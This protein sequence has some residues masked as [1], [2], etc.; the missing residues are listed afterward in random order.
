M[1]EIDLTAYANAFETTLSDEL[2]LVFFGQYNT[3]S[4]KNIQ[5]IERFTCLLRYLKNEKK[6]GI[7][8]LAFMQSIAT[9]LLDEIL[10]LNINFNEI[11]IYI[12]P[13]ICLVESPNLCKKY[14]KFL[15]TRFYSSEFIN[16]TYFY[17]CS[18]QMGNYIIHEPSILRSFGIFSIQSHSE[19]LYEFFSSINSE[20]LFNK[21]IRLNI[22]RQTSDIYKRH[23]LRIC[24]KTAC[25]YSAYEIIEYLLHTYET[26]F[27]E[28]EMKIVIAENIFNVN[29]YEY[30][31]HM[32]SIQTIE[33]LFQTTITT[34]SPIN[35][36]KIM[37]TSDN[38]KTIKFLGDFIVDDIYHY[39]GTIIL[40]VV[41]VYSMNT[42]KF[43][44]NRF[45]IPNNALF[46]IFD[47]ICSSKIWN[48][49]YVH[50][51]FDKY[52]NYF[53]KNTIKFLTKKKIY[54][55]EILV[56]KQSIKRQTVLLNGFEIGGNTSLFLISPIYPI[57]EAT[58][59]I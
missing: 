3:K 56:I 47:G 26:I 44:L 59:W 34:M 49:L 40:F 1:S 21:Y 5:I 57:L 8:N 33:E 2:R 4:S 28:D 51:D 11:A 17:G 24:F 20:E 42:F 25:K 13:I 12:F 58:L 15:W 16:I 10:R 41:D 36:F 14:G 48:Q 27:N 43:I 55:N 37:A 31:I 38:P 29:S 54:I 35:I 52:F 30:A 50:F 7:D 46:T 53:D 6:I 45:K 18:K 22:D 9:N 19:Q 23:L 39:L 32:L